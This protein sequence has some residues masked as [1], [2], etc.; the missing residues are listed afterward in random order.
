MSSTAPAGTRTD[1]SVATAIALVVMVA[2]GVA[3][4]LSAARAPI[5]PR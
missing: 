3:G 5:A 1:S 4:V 2:A